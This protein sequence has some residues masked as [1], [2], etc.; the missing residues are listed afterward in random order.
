[1]VRILGGFTGVE[2]S[3][4]R[5]VC[6]DLMAFA[7]AGSRTVTAVTSSRM[8]AVCD[9][10]R[11][12]EL[13]VNMDC[14][15]ARITRLCGL[16]G[17]CLSSWISRVCGH[18]QFIFR[19]LPLPSPRPIRGHKNLPPGRG[20]ACLVLNM[21]RNTLPPSL[22]Q[23]ALPG[24]KKPSDLLNLPCLFHRALTDLSR[25]LTSDTGWWYLPDRSGGVVVDAF[26]ELLE[27]FHGDAQLGGVWF[28]HGRC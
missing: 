13:N 28:L 1:M 9:P 5:I 15:R 18:E 21:V 20:R 26:T 17:G 7:D 3:W 14:S 8:R 19:R 4:H 22:F 11:W 25:E 16:R 6:G 2:R 23:F 24:F 12:H 10:A 27:H